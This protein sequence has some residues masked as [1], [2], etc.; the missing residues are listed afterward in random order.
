MDVIP[1]IITIALTVFWLFML[2][3]FVKN[4]RIHGND[5]IFWLI[6]FIF[7]SLLTA[8]Y[9]YFTQYDKRR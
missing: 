3:D 1:A 4:E 5:R 6:G 2:A 8:G 7:L 9:Y